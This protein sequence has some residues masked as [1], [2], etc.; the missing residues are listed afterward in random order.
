M[1]V[2]DLAARKTADV[3]AC[4]KQGKISRGCPPPGLQ[5]VP[6]LAERVVEQSHTSAAMWLLPWT[7]SAVT[8]RSCHNLDQ[9]QVLH[10]PLRL[11]A[12][13]SSIS[14]SG[15][16]TEQLRA[17]CQRIQVCSQECAAVLHCIADAAWYLEHA[18]P[19]D[20]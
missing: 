17:C 1:Y 4:S 15:N 3:G 12:S 7:L 19:H 8:H 14:R 2:S 13:K 11:Q 10:L 6:P 18:Y 20:C 5:G 16:G 9:W